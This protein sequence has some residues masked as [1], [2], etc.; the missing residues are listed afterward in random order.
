MLALTSIAA[1]PG[2]AATSGTTSGAEESPEIAD[3]QTRVLN[4]EEAL[5]DQAEFVAKEEGRDPEAVYRR[6]LFEH[7]V[8]AYLQE[9]DESGRLDPAFSGGKFGPGDELSATWFFKGDV[10]KS[11]AND[12][13]AASIDGLRL[14]GGQSR[15]LKELV[16]MQVAIHEAAVG[17]GYENAYSSFD[18]ASQKITVEVSD[19]P[20]DA[21]RGAERAEQVARDASQKL[22]FSVSSEDFELV[23]GSGGPPTDLEA[24]YG[25]AWMRLANGTNWCSTAF[26][27]RRNTSS[28][29]GVLTASHCEG[30]TRIVDNGTGSS[31]SAPWVAEYIGNWGDVEWHATSNLD[32][33]PQ[34]YSNTNARTTVNARIANNA[35]QEDASIC[36]FRRTQDSRDCGQVE[37]INTIAT[38]TWNGSQVTA[39]HMVDA[40]N[41]VSSGGDS[42]G[43]WYSGATAWGV[44]HGTRNSNGMRVFSKIQNAELAFGVHVQTQ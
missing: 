8:T 42:G 39:Q 7:E 34:F 33:L 14:Q 43:P 2:G 17:L 10:P 40:R 27:V 25:G 38:F 11:H 6:L 23:D 16:A 1:P 12:A 13:H 26:V 37:T 32:D 31:I 4:A 18:L 30:L 22:P 3:D 9:L 44:H 5:R 15:S 24:G 35:M 20:A 19:G 28:T 41:V 29:E 36:L 21:A